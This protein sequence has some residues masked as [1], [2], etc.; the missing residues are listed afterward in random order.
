[1]HVCDVVGRFA[2]RLRGT[3]NNGRT[4]ARTHGE[5]GISICTRTVEGKRTHMYG[6]H[7]SV[8]SA[9]FGRSNLQATVEAGRHA[10]DNTDNRL[11]SSLLVLRL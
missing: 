1:M 4:V 5:V 8:C 10:G 7:V 2:V 6:G 11:C 3:G 9:R